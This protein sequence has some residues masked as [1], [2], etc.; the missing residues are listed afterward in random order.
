MSAQQ[1]LY[2]VQPE[3]LASK[4]GLLGL[5]FFL[6]W[7]VATDVVFARTGAGLRARVEVERAIA[8]SGNKLAPFV[9][10]SGPTLALVIQ[11]AEN[12]SSEYPGKPETVWL[13]FLETLR[14]PKASPPAVVD[15]PAGNTGSS[16][17][18]VDLISNSAPASP[19]ASEVERTRATARNAKKRTRKGRR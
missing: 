6:G 9:A 13:R 2:V 17:A 12:P 18:P 14:R 16:A 19:L 8:A 15:L 5:E 11:A 1:T 10:L 3:P 7:L 4:S